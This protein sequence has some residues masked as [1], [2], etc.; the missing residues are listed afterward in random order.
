MIN[1]NQAREDREI[2]HLGS[3][4]HE[5]RNSLSSATIAHEM[6]TQGLVGTGGSTAIVLKE[7]LI[8]M[9]K[10]MDRSL[11][12]LRMRGDPLIHKENFYLNV[13][14]D[15]ILLTALSE[16]RTKGQTLKSEVPT[17]ILLKTDRHL[18]LS[19]VVNLVQNALK[20]SKQGGTIRIR[21]A[22]ANNRVIVEIE[23]DGGGVEASA[24][25]SIFKPFFSGGNNQSGMGLGLTIVKKAVVLLQGT[26]AVINN[27]GVGCVFR[28]DIPI[29]T[30]QSSVTPAVKG[31]EAVQPQANKKT[32]KP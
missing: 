8:Q 28:I 13:L 1:E 27:P 19:A 17:D 11:S 20:Y 31:T 29:E 15:Q 9:R 25:E 32:D 10:L 7:N 23:D 12:E 24:I 21:A 30:I 26:V 16:A 6:I 4:V 18:L 14:V 5:L 2:Q 22:T 3:L